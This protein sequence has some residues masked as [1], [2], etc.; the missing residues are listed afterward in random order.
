MASAYCT[1][2]RPS[3][4]LDRMF[5]IQHRVGA[6][7]NIILSAHYASASGADQKS[8][9]R[10]AVYSAVR[11]VITEY[12]EL[13]LIGVAEP[14]G[15]KGHHALRLAALH[16]ID[17]DTCVEFRDDDEPKAT[18]EALERLHNEWDWT[19][20]QFNPR[21]PWWKVVVLGGQQAVFVYHHIV[22]DGRF[23][24]MFQR[25]LLAGLNSFDEHQEP[26][27]KII[28][29]D[30]E[31]VRLEP[32]M[33]KFTTSTVSVFCVIHILLSFVFLRLFLGSR[34]L[35]TDLPRAKPHAKFALIEALPSERTKTRVATLRISAARMR[36]IVSACR[37]R[38]A[39][40][41]PLLLSMM[42]CTLACDYYPSAKVGISNCALDLRSLYPRETESPRSA[43]LLQQAG[44]HHKF[45][46]LERCRRIFHHQAWSRN[47]DGKA[48]AKAPKV[49]I[50]A[51]W[52][53]VQ[54]YRASLTKGFQTD[55]SP[56]LQKIKAGNNVS[57]D[58]EGTFKSNFPV[59]GTHLNNS[60]QL[61]NIG[62]FA[63]ESSSGP[64]KIDDMSFSAATVNGNLSY[65]ISLNTVGVE[66]GDTVVN[67][68]YED[69][70]LADDMVSGILE[71]TLERIEAIL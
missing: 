58:L 12:P 70:I 45:T 53:L 33:E 46:W 8:L 30:P 36:R 48:D 4:Y 35:F 9:T 21:Q 61:S 7:S 6:Q 50:D 3:N 13:S 23:S 25:Q 37:E 16:E 62:V 49:D 38:N 69:G 47:G 2:V 34:L 54:E 18:P 65:N 26:S 67:A 32:E 40:F 51:A 42:L 64:W 43:K 17:L 57:N 31:T 28:K 59:L 14:L 41:T 10:E 11:S 52:Q 55:P 19:D 24:Q 15:K 20:E 71:A 39:T 66:G 27:S 60:I 44:G 22:C 5:Y 68:S 1:V 63:T 56:Y 29:I